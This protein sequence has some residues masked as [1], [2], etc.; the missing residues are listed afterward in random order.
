MTV[1]KEKVSVN[2]ILITHLFSHVLLFFLLTKFFLT[3]DIIYILVYNLN[4]TYD[5][6][7]N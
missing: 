5:I 7:F 1:E 4:H 6:I 3:F 2:H